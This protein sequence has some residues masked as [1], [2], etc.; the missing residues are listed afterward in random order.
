MATLRAQRAL[1]ARLEFVD[2]NQA[3]SASVL[4]FDQ[5]MQLR[6]RDKRVVVAI[7]DPT[8]RCRVAGRCADNGLETMAVRADN[9]VVAHDAV[10][11]DG[12]ILAAFSLI[13][14]ATRIGRFFHANYHACVAHDCVIGDFVTFGPRATCNGN[15]HIGD[16]A[17][18][19]AGA[20]IKQGVPGRPLRIGADAVVGMGAVVIEDVAAGQTVVGNPARPIRA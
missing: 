2:D 6:A 7:A 8:A 17:Y 5:F 19:G 14:I 13:S 15:V 9:V 18:I 16:R 11:G 10:I 12:A 3:G 4:T 1:A 20:I